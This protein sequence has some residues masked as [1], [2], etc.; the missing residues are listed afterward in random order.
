MRYGPT[1]N[2]E[3][4]AATKTF[5]LKSNAMAFETLGDK[6]GILRDMS[7]FGFPADYVLQR[8]AIVRDMTIDRIRELAARH[9]QPQRMIWLVVGDAATQRERLGSLGFGTH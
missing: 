1:I 2:D 8:E 4:L 7:M 9:L 6:I 5:L 3:D